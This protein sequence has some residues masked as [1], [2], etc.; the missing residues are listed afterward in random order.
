M[1]LVSVG[2]H[3]LPFDRLVRKMDELAPCLGEKVLIQR[4]HTSYIPQNSDYFDF[5]T[6]TRWLELLG[7]ARLI[8]CHG[9][10]TTL[11]NAIRMQKE[12]IVVPRRQDLGEHTYS[13]E[14]E[15]AEELA[16]W[17]LVTVVGDVE[18]LQDAL[19]RP[20]AH[21][22]RFESSRSELVAGLR[23]YVGFLERPLEDAYEPGEPSIDG[24]RK[25]TSS[26]VLDRL[27]IW[28]TRP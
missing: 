18:E 21:P 6:G 3:I 28:R 23:A 5:V 2:T 11:M 17:N 10:A 16:G 7:E 24:R 13:K 25:T 1:I 26:G 20:F 14:G 9:G 27:K 15:L 4:G 8:V 19:Q 12:T 22:K